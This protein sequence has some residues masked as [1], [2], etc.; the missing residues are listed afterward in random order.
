M[1]HALG[2]L[3]ISCG[4]TGFKTVPNKD[5]VCHMTM[6]L[7]RCNLLLSLGMSWKNIIHFCDGF[8]SL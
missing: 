5:I 3:W 4:F 2:K 6:D 1:S 7:R 8:V